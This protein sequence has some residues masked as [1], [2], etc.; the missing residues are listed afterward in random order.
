MIYQHDDKVL[1]RKSLAAHFLIG[2]S[3]S[4]VFIGGIVSL[5]ASANVD[6]IKKERKARIIDTD[7]DSDGDPTGDGNN[8]RNRNILSVRSPAQNRGY[9]HASTSTAEG[10]INIQNSLCKNVLICNITQKVIVIAPEK[11]KTATPEPEN[12]KVATPE[13]EKPETATPEPENTK[14]ATPEPEKPETATPEKATTV[15]P[16][17]QKVDAPAPEAVETPAP[18]NAGP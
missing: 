9:Q 7:H 18:E 5:P 17:P 1:R 15:T 2:V 8:K 12:T 3:A 13:P 14:V 10:G 16:A 11:P 6:P 4:A